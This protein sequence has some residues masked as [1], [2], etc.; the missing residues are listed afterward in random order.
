MPSA[1][2]VNPE[3][4]KCVEYKPLL[5][6]KLVKPGEFTSITN[7]D[8]SYELFIANLLMRSRLDW[9]ITLYEFRKL[10]G[11]I[12]PLVYISEVC[13]TSMEMEISSYL[14]PIIEEISSQVERRISTETAFMLQLMEKIINLL[15]SNLF[16]PLLRERG[17]ED[18]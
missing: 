17:T 1:I 3:T 11:T 6:H 12:A 10:C 13:V 5:N 14:A 16:E 4:G 8:P 7:G 18:K 2:L 15:E 9:L